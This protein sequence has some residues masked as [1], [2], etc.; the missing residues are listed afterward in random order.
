VRKAVGCNFRLTLTRESAAA[1]VV[2]VQWTE[3]GNHDPSSPED[4]ALLRP[5]TAVIS[6]AM[7]ALREGKK[8][9][10][11]SSV[12]ER[13]VQQALAHH[14]PLPAARTQIGPVDMRALSMRDART[15]LLGPTDGQALEQLVQHKY[16]DSVLYYTRQ[17]RAA[18]GSITQHL[19]LAISTPFQQVRPVLAC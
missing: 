17:Q 1:D 8:P 16:A 6:M 11:V 7:Q 10:A 15:R 9:I 3:H 4:Q 2:K 19:E 14:G 13:H 12:I 18:D 5:A